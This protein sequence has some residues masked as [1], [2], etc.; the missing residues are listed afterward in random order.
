MEDKA[1]TKANYD[2]PVR[3][4]QANT[5]RPHNPSLGMSGMKAPQKG[6]PP[7]CT[8]KFARYLLKVIGIVFLTQS[9]YI[10]VTGIR[11]WDNQSKRWEPDQE[12]AKVPKP[13]FAFDDQVVS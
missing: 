9:D 12:F 1:L 10:L 8:A 13:G 2:L 11:L 3:E 6:M 7:M 4:P 5:P